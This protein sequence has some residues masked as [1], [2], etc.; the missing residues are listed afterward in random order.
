[1]SVRKT[2]N[3]HRSTGTNCPLP[4]PLHSPVLSTP[5]PPPNTHKTRSPCV[6]GNVNTCMSSKCS[7]TLPLYSTT[8]L[9]EHTHTQINMKLDRRTY[10]SF[11]CFIC[12][13]PPLSPPSIPSSNF[14][15]F[16][17]ESKWINVHR[18]TLHIETQPWSWDGWLEVQLVDT[19]NL[20][21]S[22]KR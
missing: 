14:L 13:N 1:M 22:P 10:D 15:P 21:Q 16:R 17:Q 18:Q 4:S 9:R 19:R 2:G 20:R 7:S 8:T 12:I 5:S 3:V 11:V 6:R